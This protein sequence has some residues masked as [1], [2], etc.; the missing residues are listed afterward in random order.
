[1]SLISHEQLVEAVGV[2]QAMH[3]IADNLRIHFETHQAHRKAWANLNFND[4]AHAIATV[5]LTLK[6]KGISEA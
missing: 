6:L 2:A 3:E 4:R 5:A 1:M